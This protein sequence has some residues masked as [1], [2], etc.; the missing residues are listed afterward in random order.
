MKQKLRVLTKTLDHKNILFFYLEKYISTTNQ[1][2]HYN[3][4]ALQ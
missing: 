4:L 2:K 3:T 1:I